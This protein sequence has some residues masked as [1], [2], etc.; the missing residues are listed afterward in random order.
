MV[1]LDFLDQLLIDLILHH[2][3]YHI[4]VA[5]TFT[6]YVLGSSIS[7]FGGVVFT[8]A[9][10]GPFSFGC[11]TIGLNEVTGLVPS[12]KSNNNKSNSN[13]LKSLKNNDNGENNIHTHPTT[14]I[15]SFDQHYAKTF[16][17]INYTY[18]KSAYRYL[19]MEIY[20]VFSL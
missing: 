20:L 3:F 10:G 8:A 12:P 14:T 4:C 19:N 17:S 15:R 6:G 2:L 7:A 1:N 9:Y 5:I 11:C 16:T 13:F 18:E